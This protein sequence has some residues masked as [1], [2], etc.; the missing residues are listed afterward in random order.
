VSSFLSDLSLTALVL[1]GIRADNHKAGREY[2]A[3]VRRGIAC[4]LLI[5]IAVLW[6]VVPIPAL[7]IIGQLS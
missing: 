2:P 3:C 5:L 7:V 6:S 1:L 4:D